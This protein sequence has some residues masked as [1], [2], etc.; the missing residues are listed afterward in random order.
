MTNSELIKEIDK[1]WTFYEDDLPHFEKGDVFIRKEDWDAIKNRKDPL[2]EI[3][4]DK[5]ELSTTAKIEIR[6]LRTEIKR[7][8]KEFT[9][10]ENKWNKEKKDLEK[11]VEASAGA[12]NYWINKYKS[13]QSSPKETTISG[14]DLCEC[15]HNRN[16]H[17]HFM[18]D[19][20]SSEVWCG[21]DNYECKCEKFTLC[22]P[23]EKKQ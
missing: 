12:I 1:E 8:E 14:E 10:K 3:F 22:S 23:K 5:I 11:N 7:L 17:T 16:K 2:D 9:R 18:H 15:G 20:L 21:G 19:M 4:V 13:S 6:K